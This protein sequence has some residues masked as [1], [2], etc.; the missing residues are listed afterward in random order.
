MSMIECIYLDDSYA[1]APDLNSVNRASSP[2]D[3]RGHARAAARPD[4]GAHGDKFQGHKATGKAENLKHNLKDLFC[5]AMNLYAPGLPVQDSEMANTGAQNRS[6]GLGGVQT[7][8]KTEAGTKP[9]PGP[10]GLCGASRQGMEA[11]HTRSECDA[12]KAEMP[13]RDEAKAA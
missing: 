11:V 1:C 4:A 10:V 5:T 6:S 13:C 12:R 7:R 2:R 3:V 9:K 8:N